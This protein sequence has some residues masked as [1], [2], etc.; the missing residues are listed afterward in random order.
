MS[1][2]IENIEK[3]GEKTESSFT[4]DDKNTERRE[5]IAA[6]KI[7][8]NFVDIFPENSSISDQNIQ[9]TE[10][11]DSNKKKYILNTLP[12]IKY[13]N[14]NFT[15]GKTHI[16]HDID[17]DLFDNSI[18]AVMGLSG[19]GKTTLLKVLCGYMS[20]GE[21]LI[22]KDIFG[23]EDIIQN[24]KGDRKKN[25][26]T[27]VEI[28]NQEHASSDTTNYIKITPKQMR[29]FS[30]L[31]PQHE[32]LP[33][34]YTVGQYL[35]FVSKIVNCE[36]KDNLVQTKEEIEQIIKTFNLDH[37]KNTK[38]GTQ[39]RGISGGERR[40]VEIISEIL[41]DRKIFFLDEPTTGLDVHN[42]QDVV[43][44][45]RSISSNHTDSG[46]QNT[47]KA[48]ILTI[49]QPA[50]NLFFMVD[51]LIIL[52]KGRI[53]CHLKTR[54]VIS[55][56]QANGFKL[57][58]YTNPAE[59]FFTDFINEF[60]FCEEKKNF[61][62][63]ISRSTIEKNIFY[64][65]KN[66]TTEIDHENID[67]YSIQSLTSKSH[68]FVLTKRNANEKKTILRAKISEFYILARRTAL[69]AF[70]KQ[71]IFSRLLQATVTGLILGLIFFRLGDKRFKLNKPSTGPLENIKPEEVQ[72]VY[73]SSSKGFLYSLLSNS[74]F[75]CAHI[76]L[77]GTYDVSI[78]REIYSYRYGCLPYYICKMF[79]NSVAILI[80]PIVSNLISFSL[81]SLPYSLKNYMLFVLI[82]CV[83]AIYGLTL[84]I[85][86]SYMFIDELIA[87]ILMPAILGPMIVLSGMVIANSETAKW[88]QFLAK[89][90]IPRYCFHI[91]C[92]N[93]FEDFESQIKNPATRKMMYE[94]DFYSFKISFFVLISFVL[95]NF[96]VAYFAFS[97]KVSKW[98]VQ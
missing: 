67:K 65:Y 6:E 88:M 35:E 42:A 5:N 28:P 66:I 43:D 70:T 52:T 55:F 37:I 96:I 22:R 34:F 87:T 41:S 77:K 47:G 64:K 54:E 44:N 57:D 89:F 60:E 38:V 11:I 93:H 12:I 16:L 53:L 40:R 95:F 18:T 86:I 31:V 19:A 63:T 36:Y 62:R 56:F 61:V 68:R 3:T 30:S 25:N 26:S 9:Q 74:L 90:S 4:I 97:R 15:A 51:N 1:K 83:A 14:I 76:G 73:I 84:G 21:I 69:T 39:Q 59:F 80:Y 91:L 24:N 27:I 72:Q 13:R 81:V 10:H 71:Q 49:H 17:L 7:Q 85:M 79:F 2:L 46:S 29:K 82:T 92:M 32:V 48:V 8:S 94:E 45:L 33:P 75:S 50:K 98:M 20:G 78:Y 23:T 58:Y